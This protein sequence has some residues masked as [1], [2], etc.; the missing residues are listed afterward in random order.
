M[1][2][3]AW[4]HQDADRLGVELEALTLGGYSPSR[5]AEAELEG[6]LRLT[7]QLQVFGDYVAA[8]VV[9]PDEYPY[10]RP[11]VAAAGLGLEHHWSPSTGELCLLERAGD[12]WDPT[13]TAA[14][15]LDRQWPEV[16]R[17][18][19][20]SLDPP[21]RRDTPAPPAA[22]VERNGGGPGEVPQAEPWT[23]YLEK[24]APLVVVVPGDATLPEHV[25][26]GTAKLQFR[27]TGG[28]TRLHRAAEGAGAVRSPIEPLP[29]A[30]LVGLTDAG[31]EPVWETAGG[32]VPYHD[33]DA[34]VIEVGWTRIDGP[35]PRADAAELWSLA[36]GEA[37]GGARNR[38][39]QVVLI[40]LPEEI[41]QRTVG[42]GWAVVV[43]SRPH[44]SAPWSAPTAGQVFRAGR[45]DLS[46]RE[47]TLA[48]MSD[49]R[50]LM[51]G[52]GGLGSALGAE[53]T[54]TGPAMFTVLDGDTVDPAT[55]VRAPSAWRTA[56]MTKS[57]AMAL[58]ALDATPYT[59]VAAIPQ[60]LGLPRL[61]SAI[62]APDQFQATWQ[63]V[64]AADVVVD[65][66]ADFGVHR[67]LSDMCAASSTAYV[68]AEATRGVHGGTVAAILPEALAAGSGCWGCLTRHRTDGTVPFAPASDGPLVQ[69]LG[70]GEPTYT[71]AGF[72][73][74]VLAS[75]TAR[76]VV[77]V[78]TGPDGYGTFSKPVHVAS[79][80][81]P[82]GAPIPAAWTTHA[83]PRHPACDHA[84]RLTAE[85]VSGGGS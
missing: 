21:V 17:L 9:Y 51:I 75:H 67:M 66:T 38:R 20:L 43:R 6:V 65:A 84:E 78:L 40:A 63:A 82:D 5:D 7:V 49:K 45:A 61:G 24:A 81:G 48:T 16:L 60:R 41:A 70:C 35:P 33:G 62:A 27:Q 44:G 10:F 50:V 29:V 80:R 3:E 11:F 69:P 79:L 22:D 13:S 55:A 39:L 25:R 2:E 58:L 71:G 1:I 83:L 34:E 57:G 4:W 73:L 59:A 85:R 53:I 76:V 54:R 36:G 31:G 64:L 72:D 18:N 32:P 47:P 14:D 74:A 8:E 68:L 52:G 15:L 46:A 28:V 26:S 23:A 30:V 19:G 77:S 42:V 12:A 37:V 56:G